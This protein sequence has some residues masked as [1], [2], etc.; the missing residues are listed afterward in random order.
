DAVGPALVREAGM[1]V[2]NDL[3]MAL[4]VTMAA[5]ALASRR[6]TAAGALVGLAIA[7]KPAAAMVLPVLWLV[8]GPAPA[9]IGVALPAAL[10]LPFLVWAHPGLHAARA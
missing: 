1:T 5:A 6:T 2:S 8:A 10:Q 9:I 4:L 3:V 7:V